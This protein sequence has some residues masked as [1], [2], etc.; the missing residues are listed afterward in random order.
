MLTPETL[1]RLQ[2]IAERQIGQTMAT[3]IALTPG[4]VL[5]LVRGYR[6]AIP[7]AAQS[8][9]AQAPKLCEWS[10]STRLLRAPML[11]VENAFKIT[12]RSEN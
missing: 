6:V 8:T 5:E 9:A 4:E 1:D 3:S 7:N 12:Y 11:R 2:A 10:V